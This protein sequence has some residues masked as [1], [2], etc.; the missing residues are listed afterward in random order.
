MRDALNTAMKTLSIFVFVLFVVVETLAA[1][2]AENPTWQVEWE[3][4]LAAAKKEGRINIY[5]W[6]PTYSLD[7][8]VFQKRYP[9]IKVV[10]VSGRGP[11]TQHRILAERRAK[12]FIADVHIDGIPNFYPAMFRTKALDPIRSALILPEVVDESKWWRGKHKYVDRE[13]KYLITFANT[14]S[15][16]TIAYNTNLVDPKEFKS[17]WDFLNPKWKGKIEARDVRRPGPGSTPTR[18]F[19]YNPKLGP[20]FLRRLFSEMD[21]GLFRDNRQGVDWLANGKFAFCFF[22]TRVPEARDSGLAVDTFRRRLKEG[23]YV[24]GA[25]VSTVC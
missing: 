19:Y 12:K 18:F 22:C 13:R 23:A 16:G 4:T 11:Q 21:I 8:G 2:A 1:S 17:Y 9:D 3:R 14:P 5:H 10:I 20:E 25:I 7:A 24:A 15:Y 6:G